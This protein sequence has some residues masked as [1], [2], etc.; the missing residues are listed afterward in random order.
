MVA[1]A[2]ANKAR[3]DW[4]A[5]LELDVAFGTHLRKGSLD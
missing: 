2:A 1:I 3:N 4:G 5:E